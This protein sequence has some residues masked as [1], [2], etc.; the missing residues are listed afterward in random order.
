MYGYISTKLRTIRLPLFIGFF[1]YTAGI[2]GLATIQP[3]DSTNAIIFA[4]LAGLGFGAPLILIVAGVHLSTPDHLIATATAA[5]TSARAVA[6]TTFTA[7]YAA[8]LNTRLK[9]YIPSYVAKAAVGAGLPQ[10]SLGPFVKAL[11]THDTSALQNV[12]GISPSIIDAGTGA[13][14]QAFADGVR[15]VYIIAAPFGVL[16]CLICLGLGDMKKTMNYHVTAPV[17]KLVAK[18][19][20]GK[21]NV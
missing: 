13:L 17:E 19:K 15:I 14:K 4:G 5:T 8:A 3:R 9:S 18:Q 1:I 16:A 2:V 11:T 12:P 10:S 7:I 21:G 20:H 6:V